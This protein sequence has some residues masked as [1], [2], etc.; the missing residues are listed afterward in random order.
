MSRAEA[1][2]SIA[3]MVFAAWDVDPDASAVEKSTVS[4]PRGKFPIKFEISV[5]AMDLPSSA[6]MAYLHKATSQVGVSCFFPKQL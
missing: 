3:S 5:P 1:P 2:A 6:R 4:F